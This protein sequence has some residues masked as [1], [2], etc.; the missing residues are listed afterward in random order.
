MKKF[1]AM[2]LLA[3]T[4]L[5]SVACNSEGG[6][7]NDTTDASSGTTDVS[8]GQTESESESAAKPTYDGVFKVGYARVDITPTT[9]PIEIDSST[10]LK[11][12]LDRIYATCVAVYDGENTALIITADVKQMDTTFCNNARKRIKVVTSIPE[13]N[14]MMSATHNHSAPP[15]IVSNS[16]SKT[17]S[18]WNAMIY[19]KLV[20]AA[21]EAIADLSDATIHV[22]TIK[23]TGMAH[24]RRYIHEDGSFSSIHYRGTSSSPRV[25]YET[26]ADDNFQMIRFV[27]EGKKDVLMTNWQ[28][29]VAHAIGIYGSSITA[30]IVYYIRQ[31]VEKKNGNVL[32]AYYQGASANINFTERVAGTSPY[33]DNYQKIG[34]ALADKVVDALADESN[35]RQVNAGKIKAKQEQFTVTYRDVD[36]SV[37]EKAKEVAASGSHTSPEYIKMLD[38][39]N[40][41]SRYEVSTI[42]SLSKLKEDTTQI[43]IAT[44]SFGDIG[45][46]AVPYEMFDT[47][48]MQIKEGSPFEMTFVLTCAGGTYSYVPAAHAIEHGGYE[49]YK[50]QFEFGTAEKVVEKLLEMLKDSNG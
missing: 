6:S 38:K 32:L 13:E 27:R 16:L 18:S 46:T 2:I 4:M 3:S 40:F 7:E 1:I 5:C 26:E 37:V 39:Y 19:N 31:I 36:A 50:T 15:V 11:D 41:K 23:T 48:G 42:I 20:D 45:F 22:G 24:V 17:R 9:L 30:D 43:P 44:L 25:A 12:V 33:T 47:N 10:V 34:M 14:I 35:F 28:A 49:V 8:Q 29:H 21:K